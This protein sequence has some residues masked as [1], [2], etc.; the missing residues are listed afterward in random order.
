M[1]EFENAREVRKFLKDQGFPI[2]LLR[3]RRT[4]GFRRD[5]YAVE[6]KDSSGLVATQSGSD[7]PTRFFGSAEAVKLL[8]D[9]NAATRG[10]NIIVG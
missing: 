9:M 7:I 4:S 8:T 5:F 10:T 3:V 1:R 2:K 6:L